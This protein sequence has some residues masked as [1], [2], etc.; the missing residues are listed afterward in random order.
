MKIKTM[1]DTH[2]YGSNHDHHARKDSTSLMAFTAANV[3]HV[4]SNFHNTLRNDM[5]T[6]EE[7]KSAVLAYCEHLCPIDDKEFSFENQGMQCTIIGRHHH[8]IADF[9]IRETGCFQRRIYQIRSSDDGSWWNLYYIFL[10]LATRDAVAESDKEIAM[11]Q[12]KNEELFNEC[13]HRQRAKGA[14]NSLYDLIILAHEKGV[15]MITKS[16]MLL[17]GRPDQIP[18]Y[19]WASTT[20]ENPISHIIDLLEQRNAE[21]AKSA[22]KDDEIEAIKAENKRLRDALLDIEDDANAKAVLGEPLNTKSI[23]MSARHGLGL[24]GMEVNRD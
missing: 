10:G 2:R 17:N 20:H 16:Y 15:P 4:H 14:G 9:D 3:G 1:E 11:L 12:K 6:T 5:K 24:A 8:G 23:L 18:V 21:R 19:T 22:A 7:I 13:V